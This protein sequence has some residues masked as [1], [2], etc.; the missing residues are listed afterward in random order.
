MPLDVG[1]SEAPQL[2]LKPVDGIAVALRSLHSIAE[3]RQS[4]DV[5]LVSFQF[6]AADDSADRICGLVPKAPLRETAL[7]GRNAYY[8]TSAGS[9][10]KVWATGM[11]MPSA[12]ICAP[13]GVSNSM[14]PRMSAVAGYLS[15]TSVNARWPLAAR[16]N[17]VGGDLRA[18][19]VAN[20]HRNVHGLRGDAVD[21]DA[22]GGS[23]VLSKA[24][25]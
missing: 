21:R 13:G 3:L 10:V 23:A 18:G 9:V 11:R 2:F 25:M 14:V 12:P 1:V 5:R 4:F 24:R 6:K 19:V 7:L 16:V 17:G 22:G 8:L 20:D 15:V